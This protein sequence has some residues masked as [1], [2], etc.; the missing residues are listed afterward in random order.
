MVNKLDEVVQKVKRN[1][2][3]RDE[4]MRY[5][6]ELAARE[7]LAREDGREEG[8]SEIILELLRENQPLSLI[9]KVSKYSVDKIAE[10]GKMNGLVVTK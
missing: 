9:S 6:Q 8:K 5:E 4:Y 2:E 3:W 10:I 7:H 1:K